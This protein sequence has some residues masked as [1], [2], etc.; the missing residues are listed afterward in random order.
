MSR[1]AA[2]DR[3]HEHTVLEISEVVVSG[4]DHAHAD[5]MR[6]SMRVDAGELA[7]VQVVNLEQAEIWADLAVGLTSPERVVSLFSVTSWMA[8][9]RRRGTGCGAASAGCSVAGIG[10]TV[11]I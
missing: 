1:A 9:T 6:G 4:T 8:W 3:R 11:S 7:L 2:L 10:L 5:V